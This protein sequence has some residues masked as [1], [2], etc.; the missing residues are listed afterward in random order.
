MLFY[1]TSSTFG[2][3]RL[4]HPPRQWDT[5]FVNGEWVC[6]PFVTKF[7]HADNPA[8][9]APCVKSMTSDFTSQNAQCSTRGFVRQIRV[10]SEI[11]Y[12]KYRIN[13]RVTENC[14]FLV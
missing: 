12:E 11:I 8:T 9:F 10:S 3:A 7:G 5:F 13:A 1:K 6:S 14:V 2:V 4:Q